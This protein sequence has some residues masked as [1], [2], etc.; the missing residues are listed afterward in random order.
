MDHC[1]FFEISIYQKTSVVLKFH[2]AI[3]YKYNSV[4]IVGFEYDYNLK[5]AICSLYFAF[6]FGHLLGIWIK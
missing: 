3:M 5:E 6:I 4:T 2:N 1:Q